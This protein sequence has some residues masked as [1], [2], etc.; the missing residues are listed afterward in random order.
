MMNLFI[1][2]LANKSE[3]SWR[4]RGYMESQFLLDIIRSVLNNKK[5]SPFFDPT[6]TICVSL[7][8]FSSR[9]QKYSSLRHKEIEHSF[10]LDPCGVEMVLYWICMD[11]LIIPI[12]DLFWVRDEHYH[13]YIWVY[14]THRYSNASLAL[15]QNK[16]VFE[17]SP[18]KWMF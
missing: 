1:R 16:Y 4:I 6:Q 15:S 7:D 18:L 2:L 11:F 3:F 13:V 9:G 14:G 12:N 5:P 17:P 10:D 8:H